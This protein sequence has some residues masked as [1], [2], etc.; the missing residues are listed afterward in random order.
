MILKKES[1]RLKDGTTVKF[2]SRAHLRQCC[3]SFNEKSAV[4]RAA[5]G[6]EQE[7][8]FE[9]SFASL[10]YTYIQDKAPGLLDYLI[11][12]QL[13]D[14][15]NDNMKAIGIFGFKIGNSW[16]YVPVFFLNGDLKGHELLYL[17]SQDSFVPMKENWINYII[18]KRPHILG[19]QAAENQDQLGVLQPDIQSLSQPPESGKFAGYQQQVRQKQWTKSSGLLSSVGNWVTQSPNKLYPGLDDRLNLPNVLASDISMCKLAMDIGEA[20][21]GIK[22][23]MDDIYGLNLIPDALRKLRSKVADSG[24]ILAKQNKHAERRTRVKRAAA[25]TQPKVDVITSKTITENLPELNEEEQKKLLRDGILV[26][27]HRTGDEVSVVY[28]TQISMELCNPDET[29]VY[30][31][32]VKPGGFERCLVIH[33]PHSGDGKKNFCTLVRLGEGDAK[34]H[35][36]YHQTRLFVQQNEQALSDDTT[37]RDWHE[38]LSDSKSLSVN[39]K[40]V[41]VLPNGQ[42]TVPF[43]VERDLGD[44]SYEVWWDNHCSYSN[45]RVGYTGDYGVECCKGPCGSE[46]NIVHFNQREGSDF[47]SNNGKL[48][49]PPE[50]KTIKVK[51]PPKC[52]SCSKTEID[53]TCDDY[54]RHPH[55]DG[56]LPVHPGDLVDIQ[57]QLVQKQ[58]SDLLSPLEQSKIARSILAR[59]VAEP[60]KTATFK[61]AE[62]K[63]WSDSHEFVINRRR[64]S[65]LAGL[66]HLIKHH[67]LREGTAR[68]MLKE[69]DHRQ[70]KRFYIKYAYGPQ[71]QGLLGPYDAMGGGPSVPMDMSAQMSTNSAY[72][73]VPIQEEDYGRYS[74]VPGMGADPQAPAL[75]DPMQNID[76]HAMQSAQQAAGSGQKEIFDTAM[77]SSML[78]A[79]RQDSFVDRYLSDLTKALD[80]LGRILF[81]FYWHNEEFMERYGKQDLPEM[82]DTLRN[83]FEVLG[84]LVLFLKQKTVDPFGA[85]NQMG[86]PNLEAASQ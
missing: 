40:Y 80:R 26:K 11:G 47:K 62:L 4:K 6:G 54:F 55:E 37:F 63:I 23:A 49:I 74:E 12:F 86:E 75:N 82:E 56:P 53:C 22:A 41:I 52:K 78:R 16:I 8:G 50:G 60:K 84:D 25:E 71:A 58:A 3:L 46:N 13:V 9:Q 65:K 39:G 77:I 15:S 81:M 2:G 35:D 36:N 21:P 48:Y 83:A 57:M 72:G 24:G 79:V 69:A 30:D 61:L 1:T 20:Y 33:Q 42:G 7:Q 18:N 28:N 85:E 19:E 34:A 70:G 66:I 43:T 17:K 27:D 51:S 5:I 31:V 67:D 45:R 64:M 73:S 59:P 76:P 44:D 14:R 10:A 38:S 29:A 32:L 68:K